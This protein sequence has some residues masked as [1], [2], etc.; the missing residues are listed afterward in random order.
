MLVIDEIVALP[1]I[2]GYWVNDQLAVQQGAAK[3]G[4]FFRGKPVLAGFSQIREPSNAILIVIKLADGQVAYGDCVTVLNAGYAG[5]PRPIRSEWVPTVSARL[6]QAFNG[7]SYARLQ[8]AFDAIDQV[9]LADIDDTLA[10]PVA[11]GVSQALLNAAAL[12]RH[13]PAARVLMD[14]FEAGGVERMPQI[15]GSAGGDWYNN[16]DKAIARRLAMFPQS[17]IQT[18]KECEALP[19][20]AGW[21]MRRLHELAPPDYRPDM[22]FDFHSALG[23]MFENRVDAVGAYLAGIVATCKGLKVY[24]EDPMLAS[25]TEEAIEQMARI[26]NWLESHGVDCGL[27]ADQWANGREQMETFMAARVVHAMQIK[28]PDNGSLKNTVWALQQSRATGTL[29]FLGG[30]NNET[31]ISSRAT[32]HMGVAFG[33]WR[34]LSK[35]GMGFDEGVMVMTN[36][37]QRVKFELG[38]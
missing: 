13:Q 31:D 19:E 15:A 25:S 11:Y 7:S 29:A 9:D 1:G 21:I 36:E 2:G 27:I 22:H 20:Y 3:D 28:M 14:E 35:P 33:A 30:S 10:L 32:V 23:R 12:A 37:L 4:F 16:V 17:A 38:L 8:D 26:R 34:M 24:F 5:R 6:S 18:A